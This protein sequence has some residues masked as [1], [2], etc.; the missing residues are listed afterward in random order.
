[1]DVNASVA[2]VLLGSG[3]SGSFTMATNT[4][5]TVGYNGITISGG[6]FNANTKTIV[7][8]GDLL[9]NGGLLNA[10]TADVEVIGGVYLTGGTF[11]TSTKALKVGGNWVKIGGVF[12]ALGAVNFNGFGGQTLIS[13]GVDANSDFLDVI[14]SFGTVNVVN[15][16]KVNAN[17]TINSGKII[18]SSVI[19]IAGNLANNSGLIQDT[20]NSSWV[21]N[22]TVAQTIKVQ[23]HMIKKV[24]ISN[25]SNSVTFLDELNATELI[26]DA[27]T[28][29][30]IEK[31]KFVVLN[32]LTLNGTSSQP[33]RLKSNIA[34]TNARLIVS[35]LQTLSFV[36]VRGISGLYGPT[37]NGTNNCVDLGYNVNWQFPDN[38]NQPTVSFTPASDIFESSVDV[39]IASTGS[40]AVIYYTLDGSTPTLAS[41]VY[42]SPI[43]IIATTIVKAISVENGIS[44]AIFAKVYTATQ[45]AIADG[46][47]YPV[48]SYGLNAIVYLGDVRRFEGEAYHVGIDGIMYTQDDY[49]VPEYDKYIQ[50]SCTQGTVEKIPDTGG[51]IFTGNGSSNYYT[52]TLT[53][54]PKSFT[55]CNN[56]MPVYESGH[57][58]P[59]FSTPDNSIQ[60][61]PSPIED[62][63]ERC[64]ADLS[65]I[66]LP[67]VGVPVRLNAVRHAKY[68]NMVP[69]SFGRGGRMS[70]FNEIRVVSSTRLLLLNLGT[71]T[72][73][74]FPFDLNSTG[75]YYRVGGDAGYIEKIIENNIVVGYKYRFPNGT[76]WIF[77][78]VIGTNHYRITEIID[79]FGNRITYDYQSNGFLLPKF[80]GCNGNFCCFFVG[81]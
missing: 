67:T 47:V 44:S 76:I 46:L 18:N 13:G 62:Y 29:I 26:G 57:G 48:K 50:W 37:L 4:V 64:D 56:S 54:G 81:V 65:Y 24:Q 77:K 71:E 9:I 40:N 7:I 22:G 15:P 59:M 34:Q 75:N 66:S 45:S 69:F 42:S 33:V 78:K 53:L 27:G 21:F 68:Y 80:R 2:G 12:N 5:L 52:I 3:F 63:Y 36:D 49:R 39:S 38:A 32:N 74:W 60:P 61:A 8:S 55:G 35:G 31:G 72:G 10:S 19:Q 28:T 51:A 43:N 23:N 41:A 1:M 73:G 30:F 14:V 20:D 25:T 79:P 17:L 16:L 11:N 58:E 6:T 70:G